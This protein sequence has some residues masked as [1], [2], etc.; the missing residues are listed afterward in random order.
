MAEEE[1]SPLWESGCGHAAM[2]SHADIEDYAAPGTQ[3][4]DDEAS[5]T[6]SATAIATGCSSTRQ[7]QA[8]V[9]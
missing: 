7:R 5:E 9:L 8:V 3:D 4:C 2:S 6:T 1:A